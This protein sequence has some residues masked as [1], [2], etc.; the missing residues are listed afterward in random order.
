MEQDRILGYFLE[1]ASE[2][3]NTI[4]QGLRKLPETVKQPTMIR[5]LFRAA[6]SIKGSAAMLGLLD[7][8]KIGDRFEANFKIL[9]EHPQLAVDTQLQSLFLESFSFLQAGI[10][11]VRGSSDP[12]RQDP[13]TPDPIGD[14]VFEELKAYLQHLL[15]AADLP[16]KSAIPAPPV[17]RDPSIEQVFGEYTSRKLDEI[18]HLCLQPDSPAIRAQIQQICQKLGNLGE[19]FD[20]LEWTHLFTA[21]RL[22]IA[23]PA[24]FLPQLGESMTIAVKQAQALVLADRHQQIVVTPDLEALIATKAPIAEHILHPNVSSGESAQHTGENLSTWKLD[25]T[26]EETT[27][28][29]EIS[30]TPVHLQAQ[31]FKSIDSNVSA[32]MDLPAAEFDA[33]AMELNEFVNSLGNEIPAEGTWLQDEDFAALDISQSEVGS[34]NDTFYQQMFAPSASTPAVPPVTDLAMAIEAVGEVAP[35]EYDEETFYTPELGDIDDADFPNFWADAQLAAPQSLFS[36]LDL[37]DPIEPQLP[38][39]LSLDRDLA[40]LAGP[41]FS[42]DRPMSDLFPSV[43]T[44]EEMAALELPPVKSDRESDDPE[45]GS[46]T[47]PEADIAALTSDDFRPDV[48]SQPTDLELEATLSEPISNLPPVTDVSCSHTS[49]VLVLEQLNASNFAAASEQPNL[50]DSNVAKLPA[51][52]DLHFLNELDAANVPADLQAANLQFLANLNEEIPSTDSDLEFEATLNEGLSSVDADLA[53]LE[54]LNDEPH[55]TGSDLLFL[56]D[57]NGDREATPATETERITSELTSWVDSSIGADR[58][59]DFAELDLNEIGI[60]DRD[61]ESSNAEDANESNLTANDNN[62]GELEL[63][64]LS[65]ANLE[66]NLNNSDILLI[67]TD[68]DIDA[69]DRELINFEVEASNSDFADLDVNLQSFDELS[70]DSSNGSSLTDLDLELLNPSEVPAAEAIAS[71]H[72]SPDSYELTDINASNENLDLDL[73]LDN[74]NDLDMTDIGTDLELLDNIESSLAED[75]SNF[76]LDLLGAN[77]TNT[78]DFSSPDFADISKSIEASATSDRLDLDLNLLDETIV[79]ASESPSQNLED[80]SELDFNFDELSS[81]LSSAELTDLDGMLELPASN[82]LDSENLDAL[83]GVA[84]GAGGAA[85]IGALA[86][87]DLDA[88]MDAPTTITAPEHSLDDLDSLFAT[89]TPTVAPT[90]RQP[91][92]EPKDRRA[93][94]SRTFDQTMKVSVKYLDNLNNLVGELVVNR[95]TLEQDQNRM[96]QFVEKL[97]SEVQKLNEVGKRMQDLYERSLMENSLVASRQQSKP[98]PTNLPNSEDISNSNN[99]GIEYDPLEMDRFTP[100]HLLSQ[101]MIELTVRVRESTADIEFVVDGSTEVT[102]TLRQITGQLQEDLTKSRMVPFAQ[103][104]DR[105]QRGVRDNGLKYGKEIALT[106]EGRDT[107]IDKVILESLTDPLNHMVNN[108]IAHGIESA[109][110]RVAAGKPSEGKITIRAL[111]QGNQTIISISDDGAGIDPER[112]KNKAIE[113]GIITARQAAAM[114]KNEVYELLFLPSFSTKD[115]ADELSGRGVGMDVVKTSITDIR[116]TISTESQLGVGTTFTIRLP[117][118]LSIAKALIAINN[119]SNIAFPMDGIEDTQDVSPEQ[120]QTDAEGNQCIFW[121]DELMPFTPLSE[122]LG[123]NRPL[124]RNSF[125]SANDDDSDLVSVLILRSDGNLTAVQV[126]KIT[127]D[128]EIVIKPLQ[129]P[130]AKPLGI[131]GATV[132]GDGRI[133]PIADVMEL[134]ALAKGTLTRH[135]PTQWTDGI[136]APTVETRESMVLIVDDS[137][138]VRELLSLTFK[139]AGYRVEQARDGQEA[140]DKLRAGLPCDIVFCDI[141][142]P[143]MDGLEFLSRIQKDNALKKVPVA[144]LTSRGSDRHRQIAS[145]LGASGY[146]IKPYL[147]EALLDAAKRMIKGEVLEIV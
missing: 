65:E 114:T 143:R 18:I 48:R 28:K 31:D 9:K 45:L 53:F 79:S 14:P 19:N 20:F 41:D 66:P 22:A 139:R 63:T 73:D 106:V 51:D 93:K 124:A 133:V 94:R 39:P 129:G 127:G 85:A 74:F 23:N 100:I 40:D 83:L 111:H 112:V 108:A 4:E 50:E 5:E 42:L 145:Q 7:V 89:P 119:K 134:I 49:D 87:D 1:E 62:L 144:M 76:N 61:L 110:T 81:D 72:S 36:D 67:D 101:K 77:N 55:S 125:Y 84:V 128:Q 64:D 70:E 44:P 138:T 34:S 25:R 68:L 80:I 43:S 121:R 86:F 120:I 122:L 24:N 26:Q 142:M 140:W 146:F 35:G 16:A 6:H 57:L 130:A 99:S 115:E 56:E 104:A 141:E 113:K 78:D 132:M 107:L 137:I 58:L 54:T 3:L 147:E 131:A 12:Y 15:A 59:D 123:F 98:T 60:V 136:P 32:T 88:L 95:N 30:P 102:R 135:I 92:R 117:L 105:L 52:P 29:I 33:D 10:E 38:P 69:L 91:E 126:D 17:V 11:E 27:E 13:A 109:E 47:V 116:G 97:L 75:S 37:L 90:T 2:H 71:E 82:L 46:N 118:A 103:T 96:R 21:C 8:Q